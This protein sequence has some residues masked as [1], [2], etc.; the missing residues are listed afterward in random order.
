MLLIRKYFKNR[1]LLFRYL[2]LYSFIIVQFS[3]DISLNPIFWFFSAIFMSIQNNKFT[4]TQLG[5]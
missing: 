1:Y 4:T 2:W 5:I 3:G